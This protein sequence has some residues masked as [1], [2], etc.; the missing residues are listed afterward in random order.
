MSDATG[1]AARSGLPDGALSFLLGLLAA[2]AAVWGVHQILPQYWPAGRVDLPFWLAYSVR[3]ATSPQVL[4]AAWFRLWQADYHHYLAALATL[5]VLIWGCVFVPL[6]HRAG[7]IAP[8]ALI[9]GGVLGYAGGLA[10]PRIPEMPTVMWV[11]APALGL[12]LFG[13]AGTVLVSPLRKDAHVRGAQVVSDRKVV[14]S[15]RTV[16]KAIRKGQI[17]FADTILATEAESTHALAIGAPGSG[18]STAIDT[19]LATAIARGDPMVIADPGGEAMSR[20]WRAGDVVLNPF[21]ARC[22]KWDLFSDLT[23]DT[24]YERMAAALL[25]LSGGDESERWTQRGRNLLATLMRRYQAL[26]VGGSDAFA[27]FLQTAGPEMMAD[28]VAGTEAASLF[29]T[30]NERLRGSVIDELAPAARLLSRMAAVEGE[31]FSIRDWI[32]ASETSGDAGGSRLWLPYRI[33][34]LDSLRTAIGCW[35]GLAAMEVM[36][37]PKSRGRRVWFVADELDMLGR[38]P[39]LEQGLTNGRRY[40][41]CFGLGFQSIAQLRKTY[42]DNLAAVIEEQVATKLL[43]RSD[44]FGPDGTA[45]YGSRMIGEREVGHE[46]LSVSTKRGD[47][48]RGGTTS[49]ALRQRTERAVL[50]AQ[51]GQ[52]KT[53]EG[54]LRAA[55]SGEWRKIRLAPPTDGIALTAAYMPARWGR[56]AASGLQDDPEVADGDVDWQGAET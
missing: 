6:T 44:G 56:A 41:A 30:G 18:K 52:L 12:L 49:R 26:G 10:V 35:M 51:I 21:D 28:L 4:D 50:P 7:R 11:F 37:L 53:L 19:L 43:L 34:Q 54:F 2:A 33:N 13:M 20:Y 25:P 31:P 5:A 27:H 48:L 9:V 17:C 24:D 46:E 47:G 29:E 23:E 22:A 45:E 14:A 3:N 39:N 36:S 1:R 55:G 32:Q 40:G 42:G 8:V 15:P 38:V 16:R